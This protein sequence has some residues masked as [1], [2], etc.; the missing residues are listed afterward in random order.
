MPAGRPKT[1]P[2][3]WMQM[4]GAAAMD[5][6]TTGVGAG[7]VVAC[8]CIVTRGCGDL[9]ECMRVCVSRASHK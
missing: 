9:G 4:R 5:I 6:G 7:G 3:E 8:T 1:V 2:N